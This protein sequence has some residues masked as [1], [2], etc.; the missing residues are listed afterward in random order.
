MPR[1]QELGIAILRVVVGVVF[2]AHGAQKLFVI[3]FGGVAHMF[4]GVGI[5]MA[6]VAAIVVTLVEF[7]G[8]IA[9]ILGI[10]TRYAAAMLVVNMAVAVGKVHLHNGLFANKGGFE[11]PLTLLAACLALVLAGPGSPALSRK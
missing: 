9:L 7:G 6:H 5:P 1:M 11:F 4:Q 10:L 8:G 3:G 2:A